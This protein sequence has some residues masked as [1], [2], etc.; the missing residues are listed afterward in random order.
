M[1]RSLCPPSLSFPSIDASAVGGSSELIL[2]REKVARSL[3]TLCTVLLPFYSRHHPSSEEP[4]TAAFLT[5]IKSLQYGLKFAAAIDQPDCLNAL[6]SIT[7]II[8][9]SSIVPSLP[10]NLFALDETTTQ[11]LLHS[12]L[13]TA[14]LH[15]SLTSATTLITNTPL[16][17][18]K[19]DN[20]PMREAA[21]HGRSSILR[22]LL[23]VIPSMNPE[24]AT[25]ALNAA[26]T[27]GHSSI[28]KLLLPHVSPSPTTKH[29]VL[30]AR[31][32]NLE[33]VELFLSIDELSAGDDA[34]FR[35][36]E[37]AVAFNHQEVVMF[38]KLWMARRKLSQEA[39]MNIHDD[40]S[41][42]LKFLEEEHQPPLN[43][44]TTT[45]QTRCSSLVSS[46]GPTYLHGEVAK[47][48]QD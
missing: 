16:D 48:N 40:V 46:F 29:L 44:E 13:S 36:I 33:L 19:N 27:N 38:L 1:L 34:V 28:V 22:L 25:M 8:P 14:I 15:N 3:I 47:K 20:Q 11:S 37:W 31:Y 17:P 35:A 9:S 30:A 23:T 6:L 42:D 12:T 18:T 26:I 41:T 45:P 24:A 43:F 21:Y 7:H 5:S 4:H 39:K 10:N 32:G 2:F